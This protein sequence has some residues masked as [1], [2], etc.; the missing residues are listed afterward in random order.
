MTDNSVELAA[1][2]LTDEAWM[3]RALVLAHR[4]VALAHPN[5]MVGAIVVKNDR[6]V[7]EG[8]HTYEGRKHAEI[9]ALQEARANARRATLYLNL[10][11]CCH[12][13]RTGP[14]TKAIVEAGVKR[15]VVA[16]RDP[17]P[18]VSG[19]GIRELRAAGIAVI[20]GV[21][22]DDARRLNEAFAK[23]IRTKLPFVTLKTALTLDGRIAARTGSTTW[24]T[25]DASREEVQRMRHEADA[26]LT[27][28]GTVLTDDPRMTDR[29]KLPRRRPLLRAIVDSKLRI[30]LKSG[31]VKSAKSDALIFT[32]QS[33]D[34]SKAKSLCKA[35]VEIVQ[36]RSRGGHVDLREVLRE[37]GQREIL[38]VILEAGSELNGAALAQGLV[39]KMVLFYAPKIMGDGGVPM[40]Q[41]PSRWFERSPALS[42]L[43]FRRYGPDFAVQGYFHD[44]YRN[45]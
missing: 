25:S 10:E 18:A 42:Q 9:I 20:V 13:G 8:F 19:R 17:N 38:S 29:T 3:A 4:G 45:H 43:S 12:V 36:A 15:V 1:V 21:R 31:I 39:D 11:P 33:V 24:I 5:P 7:G 23:W 22:E 35:G 2:R 44:V 41:L 26:L 28:I 37:M 32:T 30:P 6:V 16:M 40:A 34:S 14:C 27:G